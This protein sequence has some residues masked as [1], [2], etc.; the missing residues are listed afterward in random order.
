MRKWKSTVP[1]VEFKNAYRF[2]VPFIWIDGE[3]KIAGGFQS[4]RS[5]DHPF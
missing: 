3:W 2:P 4:Q 5:W 1:V